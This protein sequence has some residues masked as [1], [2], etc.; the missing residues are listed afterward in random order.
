MEKSETVEGLSM[1]D[2]TLNWG[3]NIAE[4]WE[5]AMEQDPRIIFVTGWNEWTMGRVHGS[6][7]RPVTFIDQ[8][9]Q[10]FSRDIE[11]MR[12]GHFDDYYMQLVDYVRRFKG[13]DEVKPGMRK[14]IDIH[15]LF[16]QWEDMEPTFHDLPFGNCHRDHFGVGGDRYVNDTGRNDIDRMK[17][18]YDD[19]NVYFYVSTFDRMQRYSFTPW[20]RL[21]L[22]VEGNDFI[23]WE[24][25]Q[26]AAN[27]EL[28]DGDNSIVYKSLG[29][30]RF[31]PI[32]RAPMKREGSEM[33]LMVPRK[34]IGLENTP[35]EFQFKWADGIAG[36][37][38]I[39]DFYLNGDTAPY[40]RLNYVYRS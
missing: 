4:Q 25:Y 10:E 31:V 1:M 8:A 18:C 9:N 7:E 37:W 19:E 39:E 24:R 28:V 2:T 20:M 17:I 26:Y 21:F 23:G 12:D 27:L 14:T 30:W 33:I 13:M 15:G 35:F 34:L 29:A 16:A 6:K 3:F 38:T 36:D 11:P 22:H 40:G 5:Y 32:G